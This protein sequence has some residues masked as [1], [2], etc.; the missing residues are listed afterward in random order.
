[1]REILFRA[2]SREDGE[3]VYGDYFTAKDYLSGKRLHFI[4]TKECEAFPRGE[5]TDAVEIDPETL[6]QYT[7]L[8]DKNGVKIFEDD[9]IKHYNNTA[10]PENYATYHVK[11]YAEKAKFVVVVIGKRERYEMRKG[12]KYEVIGNI[13]DNPE[14]LKGGAE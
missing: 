6:G 5:F 3:W 14:V 8:T 12:L 10:H 11:W 4:A 9:I 13:H 2:K 7:G 1:M